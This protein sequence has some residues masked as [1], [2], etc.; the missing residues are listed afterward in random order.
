MALSTEWNKLVEKKKI[1]KKA[2]RALFRTWNERKTRFERLI[3]YGP[4]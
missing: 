2:E 3:A 1:L 4:E